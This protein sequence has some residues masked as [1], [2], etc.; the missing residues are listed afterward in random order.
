M[1]IQFRCSSCQK[2]LRVPDGST[3]RRAKCPDC[4]S[5]SSVPAAD[6]LGQPVALVEE[7]N[8]FASPTAPLSSASVAASPPVEAGAIA[9]AKIT[10]G[11]VF[12]TTLG[13]FKRKW[14]TCVLVVV[15]AAIV[16][17]LVNGVVF[18]AKALIASELP[19]E[20]AKF[21]LFAP[22]P[23]ALVTA[24]LSAGV[25]M[26]MLKIARGQPAGVGSVFSGGRRFAPFLIASIGVKLVTALG[27]VMFVFPGVYLWCALFPATLFAVDGHGLGVAFKGSWNCTQGNRMA[28]FLL[29][30]ISVGLNMA[31]AIAFGVGVFVTMAFCALL[32]SVMYLAISNQ[33]IAAAA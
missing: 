10:A 33:P 20:G 1:P 6:D 31:G 15:A 18:Y 7:P 5:V 11:Q 25:F 22:L 17:G 14:L 19:E 8:A 16:S 3:G 29:M 12:N 9:P 28:I 2:L 27:L 13:I 26:A 32:W 24:W 4:G 30:L 21:Q 23:G